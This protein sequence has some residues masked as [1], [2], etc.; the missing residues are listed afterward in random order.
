MNLYIILEKME[1]QGIT[2]TELAKTIGISAYTLR[3]RFK[4][5]TSFTIDEIKIIK[6]KLNLSTEQLIDIFFEKEVA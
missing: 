5:E 3:T 6:E 1:Q 2:R 4:K